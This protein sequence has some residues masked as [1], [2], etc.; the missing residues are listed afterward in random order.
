MVTTLKMNISKNQDN[1]QNE[2]SLK[3]LNDLR[4]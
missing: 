1:L 2:D 4:N 3:N